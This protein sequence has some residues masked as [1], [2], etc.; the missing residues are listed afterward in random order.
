[1]IKTVSQIK[2]L[3][4]EI[5]IPA[6]KSVSHRSVMFLSISKGKS[7]ITNFSSG[8]DCW[9]TLNLFKN[10]GV[11]ISVIDSKTIEI[12]STGKLI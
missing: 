6:D 2:S 1:M 4:G 11:E 9:S 7:L 3:K 5:T 12:N 8:A 10:L